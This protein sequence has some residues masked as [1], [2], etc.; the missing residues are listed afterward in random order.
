[1]YFSI[2]YSQIGE[3]IYICITCSTHTYKSMANSEI[4]VSMITLKAKQSS[5]CTN[6]GLILIQPFSLYTKPYS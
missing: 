3:G 5:K 4:W 6:R 1:M 2:N